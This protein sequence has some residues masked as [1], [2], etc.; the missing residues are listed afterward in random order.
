MPSTAYWK[1]IDKIPT[2]CIRHDDNKVDYINNIELRKHI[3]VDRVRYI[4]KELNNLDDASAF[5]LN[6]EDYL[7]FENPEQFYDWVLTLKPKDVGGKGIQGRELKRRKVEVRKG[8]ILNFIHIHTEI[9][10]KLYKSTQVE[11]LLIFS[12]VNIIFHMWRHFFALIHI[13]H[14]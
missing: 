3:I 2:Q 14:F 8:K 4:E 7:E 9:L 6:K 13:P 10:Y 1:S 5:G 12:Y 11:K